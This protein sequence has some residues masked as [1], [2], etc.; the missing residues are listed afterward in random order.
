MRVNCRLPVLLTVLL[1]LGLAAP[2]P[3]ATRAGGS[4]EI[5]DPV[6]DDLYAAAGQVIVTGPVDG[7]AVLAGGSVVVAGDVSGDALLAGGSVEVTGVVG[8]DLRAAGGQVIVRG[9]VTDQA[10]L[11]GGTVVLEPEGAVAGRLWVAG[12]SVDIAGQVGGSLR[13]TAATVRI[14]GRIEGDVEVAARSIEIEPGAT[15]AG[16]FTWRSDVEPVIAED[17]RILGNIAGSTPAFDDE[18]ADPTGRGL[19]GRLVLAVAVF[20]ATAVLWRLFPDFVRRGSRKL[21]EAPV[22][23]LLSGGLAFLLT[24]LAVLVLF[25]TAIGW[26]LALVLVAGYGFALA[27]TGL[28]ALAALAEAIAGRGAAGQ[29]WSRRLLLLAVLTAGVVLL[30]GLPGVGGLVTVLLW[31]LGLGMVV[32]VLRD[33]APSPDRGALPA[34]PG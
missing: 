30:Q 9:L 24:P 33:P 6:P 13:L 19:G 32:R 34:A 25:L 7:D 29:G 16:D 23:T 21:R 5:R 8:D 1:G 28:L 17:A 10:V 12:N 26:L 3:A 4:I 11:A 31:L 18:P 15:I 14:S 20:M 27:G 22:R 2:T